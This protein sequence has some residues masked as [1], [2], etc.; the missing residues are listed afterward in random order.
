MV[1]SPDFPEDGVPNSGR[2]RAPDGD[3]QTAYIPRISDAS[4]DGVP[5]GPL[6]PPV[7][8][9][10]VPGPPRSAASGGP[11]SS[12]SPAWTTSAAPRPSAPDPAVRQPAA[13]Q[14]PAWTTCA[15]PRPGGSD[16]AVRQPASPQAPGPRPPR[17][18]QRPSAADTA[19]LRTDEPAPANGPQG[20][21]VAAAASGGPIGY[22][23]PEHDDRSTNRSSAGRRGTPPQQPPATGTGA[24]PE[25]YALAGDFRLHEPEQLPP[26]GTP[27]AD[28]PE[29][30][31]FATAH[32]SPA[33]ADGAP[34]NS[35]S[36]R[37]PAPGSPGA[38]TAPASP[39][40][41]S[42][43]TPSPTM[44]SPTTPPART[45]PAVRPDH[46]GV[47]PRAPAGGKPYPG[48]HD[49][50][51]TAIISAENA[52]TG[53]LPAVRDDS[54]P[55]FPGPAQRKP[56]GA[57][58]D[59][60]PHDADP[61]GGAKSVGAAAAAKGA[62]PAGESATRPKRG[63]KVVKLRPEQTGDGY[64]SVYSEL[65]RPTPGSR[66]RAGIRVAGELMITFGLIVLL[67]A[68]YE[69]FGN[70]AKVQ[71]EQDSLDNALAQQWDQPTVG[72]STSAAPAAPGKNLVGRLYI[73]KLDKEWVVVNGVRPQDIRYAPGH[74]PDTA[75]PGE[76]GNFSVAG[77]RIRKIF[78]RLDELRQG[79]VIGV[80][81]RKNWY[82]YRVTGQE[83]V[84][85][86]AVQVVA[87]VPGRPRARPTKAMLTLTTCNP[88]FNNYERLII[89]AELVDTVPRDQTLTD[90]GKPPA[91]AKA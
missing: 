87:P 25:Q 32:P 12:Q 66:I 73:P 82:V 38:R 43:T 68:G 61:I 11:A 18:I 1:V 46:P 16:P 26:S 41:P 33:A 79:D 44:P 19:I 10:G 24:V 64:K 63:E 57:A 31:F 23:G 29:F 56:A 37:L 54:V 2:H 21:S 35:G 39:T 51:A 77:H 9:G 13:S 89:H 17:P 84:L 48:T 15:A 50:A 71:D 90:A 40:N 80:E 72:P 75:L 52:P 7:G 5:G 45:T 49:A 27:R 88:K 6:D 62:Q 91:L 60:D 30:D 28:D 67:F 8:L 22:S 58:W 65:T 74:Y 36:P 20:T 85:P 34:A 86:S 59:K 14:P 70:S 83:V 55:V 81:T 4:P 53:L 3:A 78:W 42:P 76:I 69:V 47:P